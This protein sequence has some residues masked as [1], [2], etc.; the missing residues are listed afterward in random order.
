M[1]DSSWKV[2]SVTGN[3]IWKGQT[4]ALERCD[5]WNCSSLNKRCGVE[6]V[7]NLWGVKLITMTHNLNLRSDLRNIINSYSNAKI[8]VSSSST[9]PGAEPSWASARFR[10]SSMLPKSKQLSFQQFS[11]LETL[12][13]RRRHPSNPCMDLLWGFHHIP[14]YIF[15]Y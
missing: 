5:L 14:I 3:M 1:S 4:E 15:Y 10:L 8:P 9:H 7:T 2:V 11:F 12:D 13:W 6:T